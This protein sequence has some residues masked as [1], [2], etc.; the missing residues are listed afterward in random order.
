MEAYIYGGGQGSRLLPFTKR[1]PK[2][3]ITIFGISIL[4]IQIR[5]LIGWGINDITVLSNI[6]IDKFIAALQNKYPINISAVY[7]CSKKFDSWEKISEKMSSKNISII[8]NSDIILSPRWKNCIKEHLESGNNLTMVAY[9]GNLHGDGYEG[10]GLYIEKKNDKILNCSL[11]KGDFEEY[12]KLIGMSIID[13]KIIKDLNIKSKNKE[14]IWFPQ[15]VPYAIKNY[16]TNLIIQNYFWRDIGTWERRIEIHK[17]LEDL[18]EFTWMFRD[19]HKIKGKVFV[20]KDAI[21]GTNIKFKGFVFVDADTEIKNNC[22]IGNCIIGRGSKIE[23]RCY[24]YNVQIMDEILVK[25]GRIIKDMIV[26]RDNE[27]VIEKENST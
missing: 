15:I 12:V 9:Q 21:I 7:V 11:D 17:M 2:M 25:S 16:R 27:Y 1:F 22:S 6:R 10:Q 18:Q 4:E 8:I 3:L 14:D 20:H 26:A 19:I 5:T 13:N 23:S 24:L